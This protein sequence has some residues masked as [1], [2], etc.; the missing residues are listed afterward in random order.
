VQ[1]YGGQAVVLPYLQGRSTTRLLDTAAGRAEPDHRDQPSTAL[2]ADPS[3][4]R[5]TGPSTGRSGSPT[6]TPSSETSTPTSTPAGNPPSTERELL[7]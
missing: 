5:S 1:E 4:G 7:R 6:S 3:T 2:S